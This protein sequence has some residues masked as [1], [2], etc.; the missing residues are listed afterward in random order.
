[1]SVPEYRG[2]LAPGDAIAMR[3]NP[4]VVTRLTGADPAA[5]GASRAVLRS[6]FARGGLIRAAA[7]R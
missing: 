6:T 7:L 2:P 5:I 4:T 3:A 1:M